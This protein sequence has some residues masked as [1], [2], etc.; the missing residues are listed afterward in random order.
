[1]PKPLD[2]PD[3]RRDPDA[4]ADTVTYLAH[5]VAAARAHHYV[6]AAS[7]DEPPTWLEALEGLAR[8]GE[9]TAA[10]R[11]RAREIRGWAASL[12]PRTPDSYRSRLAACLR[13]EQLTTADLPLAASAVRAFNL[14]LYYEIRGRRSAARRARDPRRAGGSDEA[15]KPRRRG[16]PAP[17]SETA[18]G[19]EGP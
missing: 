6:A 16:R 12:R 8:N 18:R 14:H 9:V 13:H 19:P 7:T 17:R 3:A 5:A 15:Q 10:D 4:W 1:M 2:P 11:R